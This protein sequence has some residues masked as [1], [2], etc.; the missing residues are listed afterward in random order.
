[1]L[2]VFCFGLHARGPVLSLKTEYKLQ[3]YIQKC[4]PETSLSRVF[5]GFLESTMKP[6]ELTILADVFSLSMALFS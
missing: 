2:S 3:T 1:M 4:Q 6:E 5:L